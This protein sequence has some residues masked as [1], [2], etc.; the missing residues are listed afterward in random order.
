MQQS[1]QQS[2]QRLQQSPQSQQSQQSQQLQQSQQSQQLQ[3]SQQSQS[4]QSQQQSRQLQ[5]QS[6]QQSRQSQQSQQ[7]LQQSHQPQ[8]SQQ[9]YQSQ[10]SQ[11]QSQQPQQQLQRL[12]QQSQQLQQP[13]KIIQHQL[14]NNNQSLHT[15]K[16]IEKELERKII[17]NNLQQE[18]INEKQGFYN[19]QNIELINEKQGFY[20]NNKQNIELINENQDFYDSNKQNIE[21]M[22][23]NNRIN[24][25]KEQ[26]NN[27]FELLK[28]KTDEYDNNIINLNIR[29]S[30]I[31]NKEEQINK[32]INN[33]QFLF[34]TQ[35]LQLEVTNIECASQYTFN[36]NNPIN[37]VISIK[38]L[39]YSL[40]LPRFNIDENINN[41]FKFN[42]NGNDYIITIPS[43]KYLIEELIE[44]INTII[45]NENI[46]LSINT[47]QKII[48][49]SSDTND[50]IY[51]YPT[52]LS[53]INLGFKDEKNIINLNITDNIAISSDTKL[54]DNLLNKKN[55]II[56][57]QIWDLRIN[58]KI[59]L[60]L[61]NL[62]DNIP[63]GILFY[64]G[65]SVSQFK[66]E[67]PFNL[68][69]LDIH[70]KDNYGNNINFNNLFH[71]L[72]FLIEKLD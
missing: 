9:S 36:I 44:Y 49:E 17:I 5:Q 66:L 14:N 38:L 34:N 6:Q 15:E 50:N 16:S 13:H 52:H 30:N 22:N 35:Y 47:E 18:L 63:F 54:D 37:N 55:K 40:P 2:Q 25:I 64:N 72:S 1:Q 4:R 46:K 12:Q 53:K 70:F 51:I 67:N 33:Y 11:Q 26:I 31:I 43:G 28:I 39:S 23:E 8:Q 42:I 20:D 19:K 61:N 56:A 57:N 21:L 59:Y 3:Q 65:Q 69:K 58:D 48:F 27:E 71:N 68:D 45:N 60:Y 29:E 62:S 32:L 7:R 24:D 41:I 10:Q